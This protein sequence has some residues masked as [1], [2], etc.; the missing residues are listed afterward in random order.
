M[1]VYILIYQFEYIHILILR[2]Y[3]SYHVIFFSKRTHIFNIYYYYNI[4]VVYKISIII[5]SMYNYMTYIALYSKVH[6][7]AEA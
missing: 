7:R 6:R 5:Y 2:Y 3:K 4:I 1:Y